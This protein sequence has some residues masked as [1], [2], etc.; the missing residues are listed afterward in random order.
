V[1]GTAIQAD[2]GAADYNASWCWESWC[3]F[4]ARAATLPDA[5]TGNSKLHTVTLAR[6]SRCGANWREDASVVPSHGARRRARPA[7]GFA[8]AG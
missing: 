4:A 2:A 3:T 1:L 8:G 6:G 7:L 5:R